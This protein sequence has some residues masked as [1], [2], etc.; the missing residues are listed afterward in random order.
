MDETEY[1]PR[2]WN[3]AGKWAVETRDEALARALAFGRAFFTSV[4]AEFPAL[5]EAVCFLRWSEQQEDVYA[6]FEGPAGGFGVQIDPHLEYIVVW[7]SGGQAE[8][9]DWNGD[10][11]PAAVEHVRRLMAGNPD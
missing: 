9:G 10:Q 1:D 5:A 8:Y 2:R 4:F 3:V 7:G 11:V 6:V